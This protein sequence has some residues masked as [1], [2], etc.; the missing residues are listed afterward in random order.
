MLKTCI[1]VN[2][3]PQFD[4]LVYINIVYLKCIIYI[5]IYIYVYIHIYIYIHIHI[6]NDN[7][8]DEER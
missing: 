7:S 3:M 8:A 6:S 1:A 5:H 4:Q 2:K